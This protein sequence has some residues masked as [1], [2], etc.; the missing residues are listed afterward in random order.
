MKTNKQIK[1]TD[2]KR[3]HSI[4]LS[5]IAIL[6]S[7]ATA[8]IGLKETAIMREQQQLLKDQQEAAVW[9]YLQISPEFTYIG[10]SIGIYSYKVVNK[11]IGPAIIG[12]V[13][14]TFE[15]REI[16]HSA[17]GKEL[18]KKYKTGVTIL[19][20][21]NSGLDNTV[22]APGESHIVITIELLKKASSTMPIND[23]LDDL[24]AYQLH[25]CYCS[26]YGKCWRITGKEE[27][28]LSNQCTAKRDLN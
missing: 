11:W 8:L 2:K 9:P 17:L 7:S 23:Y 18:N 4:L 26:V 19:Q 13:K 25:F 27:P 1:R 15:D 3:N 6:I 12:S 14:C 16:N 21:E 20:T 10:D 24:N 22:L 5:V 28:K